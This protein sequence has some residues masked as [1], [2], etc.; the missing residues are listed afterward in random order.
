[1]NRYSQKFVSHFLSVLL[2]GSAVLAASS[3]LSADIQRRE[4]APEV[5]L[6]LGLASGK[7]ER[8]AV[9]AWSGS[10]LEGSCGSYRWEQLKAGSAFAVLK[11]VVGAKDAGAARDALAVILSLPDSGKL[12]SLA[13]DWARRQGL[14]AAGVESARKE[15]EALAKTRADL[16]REA[17]AA[18]AARTSPESAVFSTTAWTAPGA[19]Q[20]DDMSA[21]AIEAARALLARAG[22]SATLHESAHIAV[23]A[24][25]DDAAFAREAAALE[26]VFG[27]WSERF[28]AAGITVSAQMRIPVIFVSDRDRWRQ[29]VTTA[30]GGDPDKHPE[31]VTI[32]PPV[33]APTAVAAAIVLVAPEGDRSRARYAATVGLARAILHYTDAPARG[34]AFLSEALPR[35]MADVSTPKAGM[36]IALRR[37]GLA[38]VRAGASFM[39]MVAGNYADP[40][41]SSDPRGAQAM[42]Y[43]FVRW[44]WDNDPTRLLRFA[45][46]SGAWGAPGSPSLEARFTKAFGM[47]LEAADARARKWFTTND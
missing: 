3:R 43:I 44:L 41:W 2:S 38:A 30:F 16:E 10:G 29:L 45:K 12:G 17:L 42:S 1:M 36:D 13:V 37:D 34:P 6:S 32:Y 24:E 28:G 19:A 23:M 15:A 14:D 20:F 27:E 39:P 26:A 40:M 31:S 11:A 21:R 8:C 4:V 5:S 25:S 33:G 47:S 35:V 46:A 9:S 18:R 7:D 22:G